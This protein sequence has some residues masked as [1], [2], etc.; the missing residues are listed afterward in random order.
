MYIDLQSEHAVNTLQL[1]Q[2]GPA[3]TQ[4]SSV[5]PGGTLTAS[6][7]RLTTH[8]RR[9]RQPSTEGCFYVSN[10]LQHGHRMQASVRA[11][12]C[13]LPSCSNLGA[14]Q[15]FT[16]VVGSSLKCRNKHC[17]TQAPKVHCRAAAT[18]TTAAVSAGWLAGVAAAACSPLKSTPLQL[19]AALLHKT[20]QPQ[21]QSCLSRSPNP[22]TPQPR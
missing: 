16:S 17:S 3:T 20:F 10:Q 6:N 5:G 19:P 12:L 18:K 22:G 1:T 21:S 2:L 14:F 9:L 8:L 4:I 13:M 7:C 11:P 15:Y